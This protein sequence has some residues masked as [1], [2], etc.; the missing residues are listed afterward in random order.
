MLQ[1]TVLVYLYSDCTERGQDAV[2]G[3]AEGNLVELIPSISESVRAGG[4]SE[5]VKEWV[6]ANLEWL[7]Y[8]LQS[9]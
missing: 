6:F 2:R 4:I 8:Q 3:Y 7:K 5:S 1:I 9:T